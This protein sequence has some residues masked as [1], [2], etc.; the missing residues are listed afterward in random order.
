MEEAVGI[1]TKPN[2]EPVLEFGGPDQEDWEWGSGASLL[3]SFPADSPFVTE[4]PGNSANCTQRF[5]LPSSSP[6]CW[7]NIAGPVEFEHSRLL[8]LQNRA[9]LQAVTQSSGVEEDALSYNQQAQEDVQGIRADHLSMAQTIDTMQNVFLMQEE[10]RK[11][12]KEHYIFSSIKEH[13]ANTR[14]SISGREHMTG[15]LEEQL[16]SL[17]NSLHIMQHRLDKLM[18][19]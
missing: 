13:M 6:I 11:E 19:Q 10:K 15:L 16:S 5:W 14:D 2:P 4:T 7:D 17:E 1:S 8:V 9:A 3:H 18:A 12:G